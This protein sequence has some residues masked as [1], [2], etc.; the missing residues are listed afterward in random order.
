M[1]SL[2]IDGQTKLWSF[3][4]LLFHLCPSLSFQTV[5]PLQ[6]D[7]YLVRVVA[8]CFSVHRCLKFCKLVSRRAIHMSE[9][10]AIAK[11]FDTEN[12]QCVFCLQ[13]PALPMKIV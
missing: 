2:D 3:S 8:T 1:N 9:L 10:T 6:W 11:P 4:L 7:D 13:Q 12:H 5:Q